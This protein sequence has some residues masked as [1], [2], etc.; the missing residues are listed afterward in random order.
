MAH[1]QQVTAP[2]RYGYVIDATKPDMSVQFFQHDAKTG[3]LIAIT[4]D[5]Y[6]KAHPPRPIAPP[7]QIP[8]ALTPLQALH[9]EHGYFGF[10]QDK[11]KNYNAHEVHLLDG[12]VFTAEHSVAL[13]FKHLGLILLNGAC[14]AVVNL[15]GGMGYNLFCAI[16]ED[17]ATAKHRLEHMALTLGQPVLIGLQ[18]IGNAVG[19][20]LPHFGRWIYAKAQT[21]VF[22]KIAP[23]FEPLEHSDI[24][25][26]TL[27]QFDKKYH[28]LGGK[29]IA[30]ITW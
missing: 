15:V 9:R 7:E 27:E 21:G 16:F 4:Q 10:V 18:F 8:K 14:M 25:K 29:K 6:D 3:A 19:L 12:S 28:L 13:W 2:S 17:G 11:S 23:C 24:K 22:F 30:S 1:G 5:T 26:L 20:V